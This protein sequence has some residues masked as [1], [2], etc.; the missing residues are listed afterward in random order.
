MLTTI[1]QWLIKF[2][3]DSGYLQWHIPFM[4]FST[5]CGVCIKNMD[6]KKKVPTMFD[7][8]KITFQKLKQ[9]I[10]KIISTTIKP[11]LSK[12]NN[13]RK[14]NA[15]KFEYVSQML[16]TKLVNLS[17]ISSWC[18]VINTFIRLILR[19]YHPVSYNNLCQPT[20]ISCITTRCLYFKTSW[21]IT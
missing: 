5:F 21:Q 6:T 1:V 9:H 18:K 7:D 15:G 8:N 11:K 14:F 17:Q 16:P 12:H 20:I 3:Q 2:L 13:C 10:Q 4:Y 19:S